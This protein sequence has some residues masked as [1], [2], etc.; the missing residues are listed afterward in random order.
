[1][2]DYLDEREIDGYSVHFTP[3][4]PTTRSSAA[5]SVA[6]HEQER[7]DAVSP[8]TCMVY[9]GQPTNPQ[10]LR[11]P[12]RREPQD[13]AKVISV[14]HGLSGKGTEY[15]YLLE[16]ALEG[17]G[18]GSADVHVTDLVRRV[19]AIE[20]EGQGEKEE[21]EAKESIRRSLEGAEPVVG[22]ETIE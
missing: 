5:A 4:H 9:I 19:K 11:D 17:L 13:V 18:L 15:L 7:N 20:V 16:E 10:F 8:I 22:E 14:G 12:A 3:F 2:H 6:A 21:E 1:M